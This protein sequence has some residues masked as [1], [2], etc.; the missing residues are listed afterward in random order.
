MD[1]DEEHIWVAVEGMLCTI[2]VVNVK[3]HNGDPWES[4]ALSCVKCGES[5]VVEEAKPTG[6]ICFRMVPRGAA[7]HIG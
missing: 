5:D 2:A 3:I 6:V 4:S 1:R 7:H